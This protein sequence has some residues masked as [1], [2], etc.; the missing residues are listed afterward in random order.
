LGYLNLNDNEKSQWRVRELTSVY[1]NCKGNY[2]K[3]VLHHGHVNSLNLYNQ[4]GIVALNVLGS[5]IE[6]NP[7][8]NLEFDMEFDETTAAQIRE[9]TKAKQKAV[10]IEDFDEAKRLKFAI[11]HLKK[12]GS[13]LASLERQKKQA[14]AEEDFD[15]A[16]RLKYEIQS[17]RTRMTGNP[18]V[19]GEMKEKE[20]RNLFPGNGDQYN[21]QQVQY[22]PQQM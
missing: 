10:Q 9:F 6:K 13:K 21:S 18:T 20:Q 5:A 17:I 2:L 4:V 1:I 12:A 15:A 16:K 7:I 11:E 22:P 8:D 19:N 14:V 3:F